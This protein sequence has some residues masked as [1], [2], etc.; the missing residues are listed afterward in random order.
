MH[1]RAYSIAEDY[2]ERIGGSVKPSGCLQG[3]SRRLYRT[4]RGE[5]KTHHLMQIIADL[6]IPN[7]S[8]GSVKPKRNSG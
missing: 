1:I 8:G 2:T 6:I 5:C 7:E 4:N 3:Q